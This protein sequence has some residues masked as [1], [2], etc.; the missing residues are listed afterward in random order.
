MKA[1]LGQYK[2]RRFRNVWAI[3]QVNSVSESGN[4]WSENILRDEIFGFAKDAMAR[5]YTLNGWGTPKCYPKWM[6][7]EAARYRII[8]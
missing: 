5:M 3:T 1:I 2:F 7:D 4:S 8:A 6:L